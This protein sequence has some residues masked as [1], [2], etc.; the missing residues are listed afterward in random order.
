MRFWDSSAVLPLIV[1]ESSTKWSQ[2]LYGEDPRVVVWCLSA[3]EVWSGISRKRRESVLGSPDIRSARK[4]LD[5]LSA[6]WTEVDDVAPVRSR[7]IRL[8]EVHA[9]RAAD[10]TQLAAALV[11]VA[12]RPDRFPFVTLDAQLAEAADREGFDVICPTLE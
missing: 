12:D 4:R 3:V 5:R 8:L 11:L 2:R 1:R 9:L 7:A 6:D 10:A